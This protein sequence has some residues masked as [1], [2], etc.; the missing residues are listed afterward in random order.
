MSEEKP[1]VE[2]P[3]CGLDDLIGLVKFNSARKWVSSKLNM[4]TSLSYSRGKD[5]YYY[6]VTLSVNKMTPTW[7]K[8]VMQDPNHEGMY[9]KIIGQGYDLGNTL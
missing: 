1:I 2:L 6:F 4:D 7:V 3:E 5:G 9:L 8:I